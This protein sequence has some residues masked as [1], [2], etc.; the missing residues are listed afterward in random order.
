MGEG[1]GKD[2]GNDG[3]RFL[4]PDF[5]SVKCSGSPREM[6]AAVLGAWAE[7]PRRVE[8]S[9]LLHGLTPAAPFA[10]L[11]GSRLVWKHRSRTVVFKAKESPWGGSAPAPHCSQHRPFLSGQHFTSRCQ[12]RC[13]AQKA[14]F[15]L[16]GRESLPKPAPF[17]PAMPSHSSSTSS[18][19]QPVSPS[20][21]AFTPE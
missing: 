11:A 13:P 1:W 20:S 9:A 3:G 14:P 16:G 4:S 15:Q 6:N 8:R 18:H 12:E 2:R 17:T 5:P 21:P 7:T 10:H 19:P